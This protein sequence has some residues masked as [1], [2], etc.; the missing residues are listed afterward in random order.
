[1]RSEIESAKCA[2]W[3]MRSFMQVSIIVFAKD[4][5]TLTGEESRGLCGRTSLELRRNILPHR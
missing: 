5:V 4:L 1:M 2:V 3:P